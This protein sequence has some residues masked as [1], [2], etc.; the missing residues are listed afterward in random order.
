MSETRHSPGVRL[1]DDHVSRP[2]V[3]GSLAFIVLATLFFIGWA[4]VLYGGSLQDYHVPGPPERVT[5]PAAPATISSVRQTLI[6]G[7]R[8]G[9]RVVREQREAMSSW[10]W[11][12]RQAGIVSMPIEEAMRLLVEEGEG[13]P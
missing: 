12:D 2:L 6:L 8:E 13:A 11:V 4:W 9:Q 7:E 10:G 3:W 5:P 1:A